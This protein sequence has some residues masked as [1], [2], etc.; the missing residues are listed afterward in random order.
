MPARFTVQASANS[1]VSAIIRNTRFAE[2]IRGHAQGHG[3]FTASN[4][5]VEPT[6]FVANG[7]RLD[8]IRGPIGYLKVDVETHE[9]SRG[10]CGFPGC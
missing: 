7:I 1:M 5:I 8:S 2:H 4:A 10:G 3:S 6:F 9:E